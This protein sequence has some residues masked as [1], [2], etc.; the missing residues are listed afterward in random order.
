VLTA[1]ERNLLNGPAIP[2]LM[3]FGTHARMLVAIPL[4]FLAEAFFDRR[5]T[6][7]L[8]KIFGA[9]LIPPH[10]Q[11]SFERALRRTMR[12]RDAWMIEA[13]L[14]VLTVATIF[15]GVRSDLPLDLSTW[16]TTNAGQLSLAG[17]WYS[18]VSIWFFQ[19]LL[20]R[21]LVRLLVWT[22]LLWSIARLDLQLVATHPD[23]AGGLGGLGVAHVDLAPLNFGGS[24]MLGASFAEQMVFGGADPTSFVLPL[25]AAVTGSTLALVA[26][27]GIFFHQ[28]LAL[29]QKGLIDY[30]AL[31]TGYTRAF[32]AKWIGSRDLHEGAMLGTADL[33]SL[34]DLAGSFDVIR[35][36]R[37][38]PIAPSQIFLLAG[39]AVIPLS[40]LLLVTFELDEIIISIVRGVLHL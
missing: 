9:R 18:V 19:F 5:V 40:P 2:F 33:Q 24:A 31:A 26:P 20:W 28:L 1:L 37:L 14:A 10:E 11:P 25:A 27:L 29:K 36:M 6:D 3:S 38:W 13:A 17:W 21:W 39:A 34:A 15:S 8:Q 7:V 35:G 30:G 22:R 16:R 23:R 32:E 4:F 12:W